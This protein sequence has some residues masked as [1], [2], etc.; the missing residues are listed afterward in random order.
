MCISTLTILDEGRCGNNKT[1]IPS[2]HDDD[3]D[4]GQVVLQ[5]FYLLVTVMI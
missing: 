4:D 2:I 3:D 1:L 5:G